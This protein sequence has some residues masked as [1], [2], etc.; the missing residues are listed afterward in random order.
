[1]TIHPIIIIPNPILRIT[2]KPVNAVTD[3]T[4]RLMDDMLETMYHAHGIGLAAIQI[5]IA[6]RIIVM[7]L[8]EQKD[9]DSPDT[10]MIRTPF[11]FINP[12]IIWTSEEKNSHKEGC[13]SL[14]ETYNDVIRPRQCHI[15]YLDYHG[16]A[17][18]MKCDDLRATCIQHEIDHLNGIV[19][20]DHISRIKRDRAIKKLQKRN[21]KPT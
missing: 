12:E 5:G 18:E 17:Q 11:Y 16:V 13:L 14:P 20:I 6:Q 2:S 3:T 15:R 1:M 9:N 8:S 4:H 19:F 10:P 7:D 21:Q